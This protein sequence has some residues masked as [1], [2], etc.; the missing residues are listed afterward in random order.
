M[1]ILDP[2]GIELFVE[3]RASTLYPMVPLASQALFEEL[4]YQ[5][6]P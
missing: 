3:S 6:V 2:A 4:A 5:G 1:A